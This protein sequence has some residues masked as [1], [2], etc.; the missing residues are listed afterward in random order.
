MPK[1]IAKFLDGHA[2]LSHDHHDEE[3]C[4]LL[5]HPALGQRERLQT[6]TIYREKHDSSD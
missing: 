1:Q 4:E 2:Y 3:I 5:Q 6:P